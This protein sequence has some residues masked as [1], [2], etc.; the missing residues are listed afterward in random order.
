MPRGKSSKKDNSDKKRKTY[1]YI[2]LA[3]APTADSEAKH[4]IYG[5]I[6]DATFPYKT[7]TG[8]FL[9]VMKITDPSLQKKT[10]GRVETAQLV[11]Y[12]KRFHDLPINHRL[13]DIIRVHRATL[14]LYKGMRQYN[15]TVHYNA[16]WA[17]FS[18][19]NKSVQEEVGA[20]KRVEPYHP[21]NFLG[22]NPTLEKVDQKIIESL[23]DWSKKLFRD[24][25]VV[26][27]DQYTALNQATK[28][29]GDFDVLAKIQQIHE[30]DEYTNEL[31]IRDASGSTWF[32]SAL[33]QKYPHLRFNNVIRIRG[34][35][36]DETNRKNFLILGPFSN[37]LTFISSAKVVREQNQRISEDSQSDS[38]LL[39]EEGPL[40]SPV[41]YT[42]VSKGHQSSNHSTFHEIFHEVDNSV[43]LQ[44]QNEFRVCFWIVRFEQDVRE[45]VRA[46]NKGKWSSL[47][48]QKGNG[49][50]NFSFL[51]KDASTQYNNNLYRIAVS[52]ENGAGEGFFGGL[53]ATNLYTDEKARKRVEAY[54]ENLQRFNVWVDG[55]VVRQGGNY[56]LK[57]TKIAF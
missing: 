54:C 15:A 30:K 24:H 33:K 5:V 28:A 37:I 45:F 42:Q 18:T 26:T 8:K 11:F 19:D 4:N 41:Y 23:R 2:N 43:E 22:N 52:S 49:A 35:S 10:G 6:T 39:K 9:C 17:Q 20:E 25:E 51:A 44:K 53:K 50:W 46:H 48:N 12:A 47:K 57:D 40:C 55:V 13:G 7:S 56:V 3:D 29:K 31:R 34:A 16:S 1:T 14:R 32:V 27:K 36:Y 38:A 21:F